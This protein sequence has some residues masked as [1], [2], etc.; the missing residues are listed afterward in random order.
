MNAEP[1]SRVVSL[2]SAP[3]MPNWRD[4]LA[5]RG[6]RILPDE[7]N[8]L[9]ALRID[10]ELDHLVRFNEFQQ[11]VEFARKPPWRSVQLGD[12]WEDQDDLGLQTY[13][14]TIG[15]ELRHRQSI[16][17]CVASAAK[18][19]IVHPVRQYLASLKWDGEPRLQIWLAEYLGASGYG[20]Y[21]AMVGTKFLISA[22]ARIQ[23]PGA[24]VDHVLVLEGRQG[25]G[26][27]ETVKILAGDFVTDGLPDLHSK[28]S[29]LHLQ[30]VWIVEIPEL[31]AMR[32]SELE[33]V[34][35]FLSRRVDRFR[36]PYA[37]R[38]VDVPRQCCFI[39]TTNEKMYLRDPSGNRRFWPIACG[40]RIDLEGLFRDRDQ[41]WAEAVHRYNANEAWHPVSKAE[42]ALAVEEQDARVLETALEQQVAEYLDRQ[43]AA[44]L[45]EVTTAQVFQGALGF[46]PAQDVERAGRLGRPLAEA[47]QRAGWQRVRAVGR[48]RARKVLYRLVEAHRDP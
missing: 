34:K 9:L 17:E 13:L 26:K 32:R 25:C 1:D 36:P 12:V 10:P 30:G 4:N 40:E 18:D 6:D 5:R 11:R 45:D 29:A 44:G 33:A 7:R 48:G 43:A 2:R 39:A 8:V 15:L 41:L 28:D 35:A 22:I 24:Q 21:Q 37:R 31:A 14:Q 46:D 19:W 16:A 38:S 23:Q 27:S 20:D 42:V 3:A 47:L